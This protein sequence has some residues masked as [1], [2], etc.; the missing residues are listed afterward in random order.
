[1]D[2][3]DEARIAIR[4]LLDLHGLRVAGEASSG[5]EA[6]EK[7]RRLRPGIVLL[8]INLPDMNGI[9]V[10]HKIRQTSPS[11]KILFLTIH[12]T[13]G[14]VRSFWMWSDALVS[15]SQAQTKL[16]PTLLSLIAASRKPPHA[17]TATG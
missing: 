6:I 2:D 8:D 3:R 7:V 12:D 14:L 15:K 5:K 9:Q 1:V 16:I 13:P 4:S 17:R 11:A 10:A